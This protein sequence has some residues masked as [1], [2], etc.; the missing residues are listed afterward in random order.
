MVTSR[1][2]KSNREVDRVPQRVCGSDPRIAGLQ[3]RG[4]GPPQNVLS[5]PQKAGYSGVVKSV[6]V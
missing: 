5:G 3:C 6:L 4:S 1:V 2:P